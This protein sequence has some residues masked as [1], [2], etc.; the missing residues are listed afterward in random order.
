MGICRLPR[1]RK[2]YTNELH[3]DGASR[4]KD[5]SNIKRLAYYFLNLTDSFANT[6]EQN[7]VTVYLLLLL[8]FPASLTEHPQKPS[9]LKNPLQS[10]RTASK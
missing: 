3:L 2:D 9:I 1:R 4:E 8:S 10:P 7:S 6:A 5:S